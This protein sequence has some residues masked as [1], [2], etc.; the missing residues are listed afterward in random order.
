MDTVTLAN[1]PTTFSGIPHFEDDSKRPTVNRSQSLSTGIDS[2][3]PHLSAKTSTASS[4]TPVPLDK[5]IAERL[6]RVAEE[7]QEKVTLGLLH[8]LDQ[9]KREK[10]E[11]AEHLEAQS[12]EVM[13]RLLKS[14]K[15]SLVG[16]ARVE[17][18]CST[19][20]L[21]TSTS[22]P[23]R[24]PRTSVPS[25]LQLKEREE[26]STLSPISSAIANRRQRSRSLLGSPSASPVRK[27]HSLSNVN[28]SVTHLNSR[29][30][31]ETVSNSS[32][33]PS[34]GK[35]NLLVDYLTHALEEANAME[36]KVLTLES[37]CSELTHLAEKFRTEVIELRGKVSW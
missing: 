3:P 24:Q 21:A 7:E 8:K 32:A 13:N 36:E 23:P 34:T 12:E 10:I 4:P 25:P 5:A 26:T 14:H 29:L 2:P 37:W 30:S 31:Q 20:L 9:I 19:N 18:T 22:T 11:L 27:Q 6:I 15:S 1:F 16:S 35:P 17:E 28:T 33:T